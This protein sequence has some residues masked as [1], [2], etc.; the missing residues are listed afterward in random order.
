MLGAMLGSMLDATLN[1]MLNVMLDAMRL[2][3]TCSMLCS[4]PQLDAIFFLWTAALRQRPLQSAPAEL[5]F[6]TLNKRL[7]FRISSVV[8]GCGHVAQCTLSCCHVPRTTAGVCLLPLDS[9]CLLSSAPTHIAK[10][11]HAACSDSEARPTHP[12]SSSI[13]HS[14]C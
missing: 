3:S 2:D 4:M 1:A 13:S 9:V 5:K 14:N 12:F 6:C 7:V 10:V 11:L 8:R